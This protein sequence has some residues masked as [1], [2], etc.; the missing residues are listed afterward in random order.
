[1]WRGKAAL[2]DAAS[3]QYTTALLDW[4]RGF[5]TFT[6]PVIHHPLQRLRDLALSTIPGLYFL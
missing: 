5:A 2:R 1:M 6:V 3:D 4:R